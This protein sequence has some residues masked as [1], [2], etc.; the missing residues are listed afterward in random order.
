MRFGDFR[1]NSGQALSLGRTDQRLSVNL[2]AA[3]FACDVRGALREGGGAAAAAAPVLA[4]TLSLRDGNAAGAHFVPQ[5]MRTTREMLQCDAL[6]PLLLA[7]RLV[8]VA[9]LWE[10]RSYALLRRQDVS[11]THPRHAC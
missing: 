6:T 7:L 1:R 9:L 3:P 10:P 8:S 2:G 11:G 5:L 4:P